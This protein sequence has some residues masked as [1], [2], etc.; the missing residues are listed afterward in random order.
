MFPR[1][2]KLPRHTLIRAAL[3]RVASPSASAAATRS[4]TFF[5]S[6]RCTQRSEA[7]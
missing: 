4:A 3:G 1:H 7:V 2:I 6:L 5:R